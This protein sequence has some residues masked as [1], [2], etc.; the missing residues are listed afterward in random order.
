V[1]RNQVG[2]ST[3]SANLDVYVFVRDDVRW[4]G[5]WTDRERIELAW[6]LHP[7]GGEEGRMRVEITYCVA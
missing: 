7:I 4:W 1:G 2:L 5:S 6:A 3:L